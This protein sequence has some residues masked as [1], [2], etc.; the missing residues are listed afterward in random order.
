MISDSSSGNKVNL[1]IIGINKAGTSWLHYLLDTHPD[2][3]MTKVKEHKYF[4]KLYP[5]DL[6]GYHKYFPFQ[7]G[8]KYYGE[9]T[10]TYFESKKIAE[11]IKA[12]NPNA[13]IIAIVRDPIQRLLSHYYFRKQIGVIPEKADLKEG[14]EIDPHL[15]VDSHYEKTLP[16]FLEVFGS[17][18][19]KIVSL[20]GGKKD[21]SFLWNDLQ[22]F[23][24]LNQM[25]LPDSSLKSENATGSLAFR[26]FYRTVVLPLK[27]KM[28]GLYK[29]ILQ[30]H[31]FNWIKNL[32][33]AVLGKAT[34]ERIPDS[35][36]EEL[37]GEFKP[38]YQYLDTIGF[39]DVYKN[40]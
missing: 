23:L 11:E 26:Q 12:Y 4:G 38:T 30:Y 40:N 10:P 3:Y 32:S 36:M 13:K 14:L 33:L 34:K 15:L 20:E 37:K 7:E 28:P 6:E 2:I 8:L 19:F 39:K 25:D 22:S 16:A 31:I 1:F 35:L 17:E 29:S 9:S 18:N 5:N 24:G 21:L 27:H